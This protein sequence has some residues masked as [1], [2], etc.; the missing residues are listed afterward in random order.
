M[1]L[2]T[3]V[4]EW[5][6][7]KQGP[8]P[9]HPVLSGSFQD[10]MAQMLALPKAAPH[11]S[12]GPS[13][14]KDRHRH[15]HPTLLTVSQGPSSLH[16]GHREKLGGNVPSVRQARIEGAESPQVSA[17]TGVLH[18]EANVRRAP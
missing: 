13:P 8:S 7:D 17:S 1:R 10:S 15:Q 3:T 16:P 11:S 9:D 18:T 4:S 2:L 14:G 6:E 5:F 12:W